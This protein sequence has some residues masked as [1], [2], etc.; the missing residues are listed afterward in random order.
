MPRFG[1]EEGDYV[2]SDDLPSVI[3]CTR[4]IYEDS[5]RASSSSNINHIED[6]GRKNADIRGRI[7]EL[8]AE[9]LG[10]EADK[11]S[12]ANQISL[13]L[14]EKEDLEKQ[15][16]QSNGSRV[17][18]KGKGKAQQGINY[19][20]SNFA[21]SKPLEAR[22]KAVFGI[23]EFRLCQR[24]ACNANMDNRD[25]VCIMPTGGGK[26][27][28]YQLPAL[29]TAGCTLVI[30]PLISLMSDQVLHLAEVGVEATMITST[31]PKAEKKEI[32]Q[33]LYALSERKLGPHEKEI[34]L[35]YVT[36]ERIKGDKAFLALMQR[37][38]NAKK[39]ARIVID[40]AHCV[41]Q[42]GHDFRPDYKELHIL[43]QLFP[44]VPIMALS[45]TCGPQ[46]LEDLIKTLGLR[47][48][49]DGNDA[50]PLGTVYFSSPLYRKNLHYRIVPKPDKAADQFV[51]MKEYIL[52]HHANDT[53][54]IYCYSVKDTH[55][56]AE[57]LFDISEGRIKTGVYNAS[58]APGEK[59]RL[60]IAW[61][62]GK[63]KV[64]CA[65]IAF[66]MGIDKGDVRFVLHHSVRISK[67]LEGFYQESGRAGRDGK[68][69][70][71]VLYYRPQDA[72]A[73]AGLTASEKGGSAKLHAIL[74]FAEDL[75]KCRKVQFAE[76]F[77]H[78]SHLSISSW[79]TSDVGALD[80]CGH[81]DN[82]TRAPESIE[83]R[84]MTIAT[85]QILK[86][87]QAV[88]QGGG[89]LT[90]S[91]LAALVRGGRIGSF[92]VAV[93]K[94]G[95][96]GGADGVGKGSVDLDDLV[97]GPVEMKKLDIEH[98]LVQLLT[99]KYL[100]EE[101]HQTSYQV[102][103]YLA[104]GPLAAR[105][106]HHQT[107]ESVSSNANLKLEL[108]F[109]K[110]ASKAKAKDKGKAKDTGKKKDVNGSSKSSI[111]KKRR[112]SGANKDEDAEE[113][114]DGGS[115]SFEDDED[116]DERDNLGHRNRPPSKR[117]AVMPSRTAAAAHTASDGYEEIDI[118]A[119]DLDDSDSEVTYDWSHSM[120][121]EPR[122]KRRR[123]SSDTNVGGTQAGY[124]MNIVKEGDN[125]VMVLS[126]D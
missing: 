66:G 76:Y 34:K 15:L 54:I 75:R 84:D 114:S 64:V 100:Q 16:V 38:D 117:G 95:K 11:A 19:T 74:E 106:T 51:A 10:L 71:C 6:Y 59:E 62:A 9:L 30:S 5:A 42:L 41:S 91:G 116:D 85:W 65:T 56:V 126:S 87:L 39:L 68:D 124:R 45:A 24:G 110:A 14:Q 23:N 102:L 60:H 61:R 32:I 119:S 113:R 17:D 35:A 83:R 37:L 96:K 58:V 12:I 70:D 33:R 73:L 53:G 92:D 103:A 26:S 107:R 46:V 122:A 79:S 99:R 25:I 69:S 4:Q 72:S 67:S 52:E 78:S 81:C 13:R 111:P 108:Y 121:D 49:I 40:E 44:R 82:C 80:P 29:M 98:L 57:K 20:T 86:V 47:K 21:W 123:K 43:R 105:L 2:A 31:T 112:S 55:T 48:V 97:G 50:D 63:V 104:P 90:L 93:K 28:T 77:S 120:R 125:E 118:Y 18:P 115:V 7:A 22:M 27:L 3:E 88:R 8:D 36:P 94:K 101:L 109:V 1:F 89:R